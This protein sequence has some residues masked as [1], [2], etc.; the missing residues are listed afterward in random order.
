MVRGKAKGIGSFFGKVREE[1][2]FLN[3]WSGKLR[4]IAKRQGKAREICSQL[5]FYVI[6]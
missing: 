1:F 5:Q 3:F 6:N 2:G 4:I